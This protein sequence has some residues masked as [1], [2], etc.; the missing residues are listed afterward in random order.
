MIVYKF[1]QGVNSG[2]GREAAVVGGRGTVSGSCG[3]AALSR[4]QCLFTGSIPALVMGMREK[5]GIFLTC[6]IHTHHL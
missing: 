4:K 1:N 2:P 3:L 6:H 5:I